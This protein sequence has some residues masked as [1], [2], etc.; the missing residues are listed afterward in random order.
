MS[1]SIP[2]PS[3]GWQ[4]Q[5]GPWPQDGYVDAIGDEFMSRSGEGIQ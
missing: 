5:Q 2:E 4:T 1:C 3:A